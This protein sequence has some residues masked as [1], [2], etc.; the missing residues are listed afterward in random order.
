[1]KNDWTK[2]EAIAPPEKWLDMYKHYQEL[3]TQEDVA[4]FWLD[5]YQIANTERKKLRAKGMKWISVKDQLPEYD[6][7]VL[8]C[9]ESGYMFIDEIDHDNDWEHFSKIRSMF[10]PDH[11]THWMPLPASPEE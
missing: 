9:M 4:G 11:I 10:S 7:L 6:T 5:Q 8:W 1:M 3:I 2:L